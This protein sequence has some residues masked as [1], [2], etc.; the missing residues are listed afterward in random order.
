VYTQL[1]QNN[2]QDIPPQGW[3][4]AA[5]QLDQLDFVLT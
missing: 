5:Q 2:F 4:L 3:P 1:G